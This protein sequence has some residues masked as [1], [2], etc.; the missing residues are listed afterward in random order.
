MLIYGMHSCKDAIL[1][2]KKKILKIY[3]LHSIKVPDWITYTDSSKI[4]KIGVT[5]FN[6]MLPLHAVHQGIAIEVEDII[7]C[8]DI[9]TLANSAKNCVVA[10]LDGITDPHNLG[11]IIRTAAAF[12][13]NNVILTER[14]SC[15]VTGVVA[16]TASGGLEHVKIHLSKNL[17]QTI[18]QLKSY[19][20][21]VVSLCESGAQFLHEINLRGKTCLIFGAEGKGIRRLPKE[22]SDFI[23]R[24]PTKSSFST[25]NVSTSAAIAFYEIAK[26]NDFSL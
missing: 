20:F 21:W 7:Y 10:M 25:L 5:D 23:A 24:L 17:S 15:K 2:G 4:L 19:G 1:T 18:D 11:A 13:I 16:K 12:G 8:D 26:Q 14:S 9:S 6:E 3:V 22:K